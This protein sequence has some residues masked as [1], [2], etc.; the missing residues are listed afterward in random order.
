MKRKSFTYSIAQAATIMLFCAYAVALQAAEPK[1]V[2]NYLPPIWKAGSA[3]GKVVWSELTAASAKQY[4]V[5]VMLH[6]VWDGGGGYYVKPYDTDYLNAVDA[7]GNFSVLITT[8]GID[9]EVDEVIFYF[10]KRSEITKADVASPTAMTG[11]YLATITHQR[12]LFVNPPQPP[13]ANIRSGFVPAGAEIRLSGQGN[14]TIIYTLDGS[15]PVTSSTSRTYTNQLFRV[16]ANGSLLIKAVVRLSDKYSSVASLVWFPQESVTTPFWGL[17]VSLVLNGEAFGQPL[18]E[19]VTRERMAPVT[20]LTKWI[21][22]FGTRNNG[23][24]YVNQIA[25]EAGL[26]TV[27]GVY[28]SSNTADNQSQIEGLRQILLKGPAPDCIAVGNETSLS[29]VPPA[30]LESCVD[31]V[32]EMV[33]K[34]GLAI[35]VGSADIAYTTWNESLLEKMDFLGVNIY[36][37]TWDKTPENQMLGAL[38][39]TYAQTLAEFP[40]KLVLLTETGT[41]YSGGS[42]SIP[43]VAGA[44]QTP[45]ERKAANYLC[46]FIEWIHNEQIPSFYFEVYDEPAKSQNGGHPIESYFGI[47]DGNRQIHSF[48]RQCIGTYIDT[49]I[50]EITSNGKSTATIHPNPTDG[51]FTLTVTED[52]SY[53]IRITDLSGRI[54]LSESVSGTSNQLNI[55]SF[56]AGVYLLT[57]DSATFSTTMKIV[58]K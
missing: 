6:A 45:S 2:V 44:T 22:T 11:K 36:T 56:P 40:S 57:I 18:T 30:T 23:L 49:S 19:A 25:K 58:K 4:A 46:G 7:S 39:E 37:G 50:K 51:K 9:T 13:V 41:P 20:K 53:R 26:H 33:L 3:S 38:K 29:G 54:Y 8:G 52:G 43:G 5:I 17:N 14:G 35:P 10:V 47:M 31:A 28:I 48:Y 1:I 21:R 34:Q 55:S 42:Y 24:E 27:I 15:N 16:P 12:S 32:R